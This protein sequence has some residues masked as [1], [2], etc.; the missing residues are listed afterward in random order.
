MARARCLLFCWVFS[1]AQPKQDMCR[2]H[3]LLHDREQVLAQLAQVQF[4]AQ[5]CAEG[6]HGLGRIILPTV[7]ATVND[8]LNPMTLF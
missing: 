5:R 6:L 7:E 2:L 4:I 1:W 3:R 8:P